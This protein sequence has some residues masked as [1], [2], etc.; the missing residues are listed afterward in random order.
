[1]ILPT[2]GRTCAQSIGRQEVITPPL[3]VTSSPAMA[4]VMDGLPLSFNVLMTDTFKNTQAHTLPLY[5]RVSLFP[6]TVYLP[7]KY[8]QSTTSALHTKKVKCF[9]YEDV[10]RAGGAS[11]LTFLSLPVALMW[12]HGDLAFFIFFSFQACSWKM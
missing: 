12:S 7:L 11:S 3:A 9:L 5:L 10:W 1:M 6:A 8:T 2:P 4:C